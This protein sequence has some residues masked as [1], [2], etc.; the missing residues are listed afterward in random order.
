MNSPSA[1]SNVR[2]L[3]MAIPYFDPATVDLNRRWLILMSDGAHNSGTH[4][5]NEFIEPT[6]PAGKSLADKKIKV[7]AVAYG[8]RGSADVDIDLLKNIVAG[9]ALG[10]ETHEVFAG[11]LRSTNEAI[12]AATFVLSVAA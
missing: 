2:V 6:A 4:H 12:S 8:K 10:G 3:E 11:A 5:P 1:L 9:A 7:F